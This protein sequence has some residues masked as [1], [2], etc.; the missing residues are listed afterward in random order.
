MFSGSNKY[1]IRLPIYGNLTYGPLFKT[2]YDS[3]GK[4]GVEPPQE[5][6]DIV[7]L[8]DKAKSATPEERTQIAQQIYK[9]WPQ[10]LFDI[11]TVGL[12]AMDQGVVVVNNNLK[13]V[14]ENLTK[15]WAL[16]TPGNG[17]PETWFFA[18]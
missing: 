18:K 9:L 17:K 11:G 14:P 2:W 7:A 4:E 1:D 10:N 12:T 15:D 6:K 16:R 8:Q 3:S 5:W 13:N